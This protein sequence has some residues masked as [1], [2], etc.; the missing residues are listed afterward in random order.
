MRKAYIIIYD[1]E[2]GSRDNL[3]SVF[4]RMSR[5]ATWRFDVPNCFYVISEY[6]AQALYDEFISING[7][8][9]RFMF[10]EASSN[11]QGQMLLDTWHLLTN[12]YHKP[13]EK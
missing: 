7:T 5:I 12:T 9:G 2:V 1:E 11:R 4:N 3:K 6:S 10:M 13:K 8:K